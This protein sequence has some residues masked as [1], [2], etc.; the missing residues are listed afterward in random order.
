MPGAQLKNIN[1]R[2]INKDDQV[3]LSED[4]RIL[5]IRMSI[6]DSVDQI[7]VLVEASA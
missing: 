4:R 6:Q 5:Y 2:G 1:R 3:E 7:R